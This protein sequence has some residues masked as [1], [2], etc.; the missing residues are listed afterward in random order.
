MQIF[1]ET[2]RLFLRELMPS[3]KNGMFELDADTEVHRYL[4]NHPVQNIKEAEEAIA[5]IRQ[6]YTDNG[7]GRWA[8]IEKATGDFVGWGGFKLVTSV[9]NNHSN[10][11]DIG[12]RFIKRY[13]GKGYATESARA[14]VDYGFQQLKLQEI[15]A[16]A[17]AGNKESRHVLEKIGL[18]FV[19]KFSYEGVAHD[20]FQLTKA[21]WI[22]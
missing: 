17:D 9:I 20:W 7:I 14:V 1:I 18:S 10:Y 4:G 21:N 13:W 5:F 16:F 12:Y 15:Y 19:E 22:K 3:D 11:H 2:E 6:Q 8:I